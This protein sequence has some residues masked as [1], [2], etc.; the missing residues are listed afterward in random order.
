MRN[1]EP[2]WNIA[3]E[4]TDPAYIT[5]LTHGDSVILFLASAFLLASAILFALKTKLRGR[6]II[7]SGS[8]IY[9]V[10]SVAS[11]IL[12]SVFSFWSSGIDFIV[13]SSF[14]PKL[15]LLVASIGFCVMSFSLAKANKSQA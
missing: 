12:G 8:L 14:L 15:G 1:S 5:V 6:Y 7:F 11:G 13:L 9:T 4:Q 2:L 10:S 3:I